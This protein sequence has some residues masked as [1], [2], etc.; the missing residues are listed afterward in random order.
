MNLGSANWDFE[1]D[2]PEAVLALSTELFTAREQK[3]L[4]EQ[5]QLTE[6]LKDLAHTSL[7]SYPLKVLHAGATEVPDF[8]LLCGS[9]SLAVEVAKIAGQSVEK[10]RALRLDQTIE[11]TRLLRLGARTKKT[12]II[13]T[14]VLNE[15]FVFPVSFREHNEIWER[16]ALN[17][18]RDKAKILV[19]DRFRRGD[20]NWLVLWDRIGSPT[21][22]LP[23]FGRIL[24]SFWGAE[25]YSKVFLQDQDFQWSAVFERDQYT[26]LRGCSD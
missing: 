16:E 10:A 20:E 24:T 23:I 21:D 8:Q 14:A 26:I 4:D 5:V 9:R 11:T 1:A 22:Q 19:S 2:S 12:D 13:N 6:L 18:L 25:W 7:I 3:H 17:R 15:Q